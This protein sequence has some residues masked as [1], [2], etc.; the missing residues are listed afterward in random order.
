MKKMIKSVAVFVTTC[1]L[2][3]ASALAAT[4]SVAST[5]ALA[6]A[7]VVVTNWIQ[8][9][10]TGWYNE[11]DKEFTLT[12]AEE[13][14]GLAKLVN[15]GNTFAGKT[16]TLDG[17][18]DLAA[19]TWP[20]IGI[21]NE[22]AVGNAAFQG[23][24]N[25]N[26]HKIAGVTFGESDSGLK[27]RGFFNQI[28]KATIQNVTIECKGF[29]EGTTGT[30]GGAVLVGHA[31]SST[32]ESCVTEGALNVT[33]NA[34]GLVVRISSDQGFGCVIR[35]CTNKANLESNYTKM[36]GIAAFTQT[37]Y[38]TPV[39]ENCVNEGA[40]TSTTAKFDGNYAGMTS[41]RVDGGIGG[42]I[43]WVGYGGSDPFITIKDCSN[44]GS[45]TATSAEKTP[46]G[47]IAGQIWTN[48]TIDGTNTGCVDTLAVDHSPV[49]GL[50]Y[51]TVTEVEGRKVATYIKNEN[52]VPGETTYLVTASNDYGNWIKPVVAL[53][54]NESITFDISLARID[55]T[56]ITAATGVSV[57][58]NG[59]T[60]TYKANPMTYP[61]FLEA[62]ESANYNYDGAGTVVKIAP[63][64]LNFFAHGSGV[65]QTSI[66]H[67]GDI[68]IKNVN[69]TA[70]YPEGDTSK[71]TELIFTNIGA[72]TLEKC[73]FANKV[74][75]STQG[76]STKLVVRN[77]AFTGNTGRYALHCIHSPI[78]EVTGC[79]FDNVRGG[80]YLDKSKT[81]VTV[82]G[83]T[84]ANIIED[85][86]A[87]QF[88]SSTDNPTTITLTGNT[89]DNSGAFIRQ[90]NE[91]LLD[92]LD[93]QEIA[94]NNTLEGGVFTSDTKFFYVAQVNDMKFL[95]LA[96]AI[97][98]VEADDDEVKLLADV[99]YT[100]A[101]ANHV[102]IEKSL[103]L[104]LG[105]YTLTSTTAG[106]AVLRIC[107]PNAENAISVTVKATSG[108][109]K[110]TADRLPIYAGLV[111]RA[112][113]NTIIEGGNYESGWF[114]AVYQNNGLCTIN[115][116]SYK[117]A[118]NTRLLDNYDG[119]GGEFM[120]NGGKF[121]G[122]NP[123][124]MSINQGDHH[125]HTSIKDGMT[126]VLD[127]DGWYTVAEGKL[128]ARVYCT[129]Y[130]TNGGKVGAAHSHCYSTLLDAVNAAQ[131]CDTTITLESNYT[132]RDDEIDALYHLP[133]NSTLDLKGNTLTIEEIE[134]VAKFAGKN[135]TIKNGT[136]THRKEA[137]RQYTL[138]LGDTTLETSVTLEN[139]NIGKAGIHVY[140]GATVTIKNTAVTLYALSKW[141]AVY[142]E[143]GSKVTVESGTFTGSTKDGKDVLYAVN[144]GDIIVT[145][146]TFSKNLDNAHLPD[147]YI[148][149]KAK[150]EDGSF[151]S[152]FIVKKGT[153]AAKIDSVGYE[154]LQD[155]VADS[156]AGDVI[157]LLAD[158]EFETTGTEDGSPMAAKSVTIDGQNQYTFTAIGAGVGPILVT[159]GTL[160]LQNLT[161]V[162]KSVSYKEGAWEFGYLE[163]GGKLVAEGVVFKDPI[164]FE[165]SEA[166][167]KTCTFTG[168]TT[169]LPQYG[170]WIHN[171]EASFEGCTFTGTRGLKAHGQYGSEVATLVVDG[172]QFSVTDK[173]GV[174]L[175]DVPGATVTIKESTFNGVSAGD[176]NQYSFE[177]D[178]DL[179]EFNLTRENNT[180]VFTE[181]GAPAAGTVKAGTYEYDPTA[182]LNAD[183]TA[184]KND[185]GTWTVVEKV[186][187]AQIGE[188]KYETLAE[189]IAA[190]EDGAIITL[191][192]G[193][194]TMPSSVANK[195]ITITGTKDAEIEMLTAVNAT[196]STIS[197]NGVTVKF[198]NDNYE[199]LQH[200][201]KVTYTNCTHIGT[202][203]L[204]AP[205]VEFT[206]CTFEMYDEK[207]EY[208]V[209]TYGA[210]NVTFK[211][212]VFNT[213]GKAI[214]VYTEGAHEA[215]I[216]LS[217]CKFTSNGTYK[218]KAAVELGQSAN[219][220]EA[221]YDLTFTDCTADANFSAN[222]STSN[223]WGNKNS[224]TTASGGGSSV[225]IDGDEVMPKP[226][227]WIQV[228]DTSWYNDT[229]G[230]FTLTTGEELAGVAKLVNAGKTF[231]DKTVKLGAD[232]D[233][234][235]YAWTPIGTSEHPF[236]GAFDGDNKSIRN[237]TAES[238]YYVGLFGLLDT[239]TVK[240][241]LLDGVRISC[242]GCSG[243]LAG[244]VRGENTFDNVDVRNLD[245]T[246]SA[247]YVGGLVG[248]IYNTQM[249]VNTIANC[250]LMVGEGAVNSIR[251]PS[252]YIGGLVGSCTSTTLSIN[253]CTAT[254]LSVLNTAGYVGGFIGYPKTSALSIVDCALDGLIVTAPGEYGFAGGV[255]G[256]V[257]QATA[258][259]ENITVTDITIDAAG[260]DAAGIMARNYGNK[261]VTFKNC[262][263]GGNIQ[264][265]SAGYTSGI[266]SRIEYYGNAIENCSVIG[267]EG[268]NSTIDGGE[269]GGYVGGIYSWMPEGKF[270]VKN[271]RVEN[272]TI[273]AGQKVGGI[274]G[275]LHYGNTASDLTVKNVA[276]LAQGTSPSFGL[277]FGENNAASDKEYKIN[278]IYG[279][280]IDN[281]TVNGASAP[282]ISSVAYGP[283]DSTGGT[284]A[285]ANPVFDDA[286]KIVGGTFD[287]FDENLAENVLASGY[288][289]VKDGE[290]YTVV[291]AAAKIGE[292]YY[293][294][295][296][297][298]IDAAEDGAV[299]T[300]F[301]GTH[302]MPGSVA[303]KNITIKGNANANREDVV[304]EMLTT[305]NATGST[306][307]FEHL[308]AKFDNDIYEGLTHS[309]KITY[310]DCIHIGTEFLYAPTV[311]FTGCT[312]EMYDGKT[313]Y[314]VWTYGAENVTF[315]NCV[316]NTN[317]KAILVYTE[318]AHEAD[319]ALSNCEFKS[320]GTYT[321]KAAVE[322]GQSANGAE[323]S[324]DLSFTDCTADENFSA[325]N[326]TSN[327]W[328]NKNDMT[329]ASGGGS[330]VIITTNGET[331]E[332][333]MPKPAVA[334]VTDADG[335]VIGKYESFDA[336]YE[337]AFERSGEVEIKLLADGVHTST[338]LSYNPGAP[339]TYLTI[340]L[341]GHNIEARSMFYLAWENSS[342]ITVVDETN[343]GSI[344]FEEKACFYIAT[345]NT[346]TIEG[347]QLINNGSIA[348][349]QA[350]NGSFV[351]F[352]GGTYTGNVLAVGSTS[353]ATVTKAEGVDV[354]APEGYEWNDAGKL[355]VG[356]QE[357]VCATIEGQSKMTLSAALAYA[358]A[359][360]GTLIT[361]D[362]GATID[363]SRWT[364]VNMSGVSF[365]LEGN[366]ATITGLKQSLFECIGWGGVTVA[367]RNL[368]MSEPAIVAGSSDGV[369][370]LAGKIA[371][372]AT[373]SIVNCHVSGGSVTTSTYAAGLVGYSGGY[374]AITFDGCSVRNVAISGGS[375]CGALL[376]H[377]NGG[378][379][380]K[381]TMV[382]NNTINNTDKK[383]KSGILIGTLN[384][385]D[386]NSID[387][388]EESESVTQYNGEAVDA[389]L[390]GCLYV[391]VTYN[392]G[393]YF[394]DPTTSYAFNDN[395]NGSVTIEDMIVEKNG[396]YFVVPA[397]AEVG[398]VTYGSIQ[399]AINAATADQ[400]VTLLKDVEEKGAEV[401]VGSGEFFI[402]ILGKAVVVDLGGFTLK[403]SFYLNN[404]AALT[405][406][407]GAIESLEG[408]ASSC[409]ESVGG[410]IVLGEKLSAHSSVRHAI[411][412]KGGTAEINGG[413]Y[414][415]DG[416]STYHVVN[417]S[418]ASTVTINGGTFTS[419]KGNSTSGGNAVMIQ[420]AASTVAIK[421][422]TFTNAAGVEGC[423]SAAAGLVISGG[424]FDT[425]TYDKYLAEGCW[426]FQKYGN[427]YKGLFFVSQK[428]KAPVA[429]VEEQGALTVIAKNYT[430]SMT[431]ETLTL[432]NVY[433]FVAP[434]K[435]GE[436]A[437]DSQY[438][439]WNAD[440]VVS[441]DK[442]IPANSIVLAGNYGSY[443]WISFTNLDAIEAGKEIRLLDLF[444]Y[445]MNY[446]E[447]C[448]LVKEFKCGVTD[449]NGVLDGVNFTVK[450]NMYQTK[451]Y[452][453][454]NTTW[455]DEVEGAEPIT[456]NEV[457]FELGSMRQYVASV[458]DSE[459]TLKGTYESFTTALDNA[460]AGDTVTVLS[461]TVDWGENFTLADDVTIR[462]GTDSDGNEIVVDAPSGYA[463]VGGVLMEPTNWLHVADTRWYNA[464]ATAFT[465]ST[466]EELAGVAKLVNG[467]TTFK[468]VTIT[469]DRDM[470]LAKYV[471]PGIGVYAKNE[472]GNAAFQGIFDGANKTVK[473]MTFADNIGASYAAGD[474]NNYRGL[475]N[476]I[477][478][479]AVV[480]NLIVSGNGF[481]KNPPSG[482]YGG[483][484]IVG[485][486]YRA[487]IRNCVAEGSISGSHNTAGV[488][489][490]IDGSQVL[491]CTN[492][493]AVSGSYNK[494]GGIIAIDQAT[495]NSSAESVVDGCVNN[496]VITSSYAEATPEAGGIGG[497]I[498]WAQYYD[499]ITVKNCTNN[500]EI[501]GGVTKGQIFG[502]SMAVTSIGG[503]NKGLATTMAVNNTAINGLN[504]ATVADGV[505]T[506]VK[507][508]EAGNTYLVTAPN[509]KPVITLA[510]GQSITF[511]QTLA[512]IGD[513]TGIK[514]ATELKSETEGNLVT[515][516][517]KG[518]VV[519]I[520]W[521][522]ETT[523]DE[524]AD[525]ATF[526]LTAKEL[527]GMTFI[528]WSGAYA[529]TAAE[530]QITVTGDIAITANY[531]PDAL[532]T[533]VKDTIEENYKND[534]ELVNVKDIVDLSLQNPTI[535]VGDV[536]GQRVADVGI[537]LMKATTLKDETTGKPNWEPVKEGEPISANWAEDGETILIRLP[538][539]KK[540]QFFRFIPV[541]GLTPPESSEPPATGG[542]VTTQEALKE[543]LSDTTTTKVEVSSG[544]YSDT[545]TV[546]A[547]KEV[548]VKDGSF[549]PPQ[550][551]V[552]IDSQ[553]QTDLVL[554]GGTYTVSEYLQII[555]SQT[556]GS[557][558]TV[559]GGTYKG[560]WLVWGGRDVEVLITGGTFDL[561]GLV[562]SDD[563]TN[564]RTTVT[565]GN[566]TLGD[567]G[568]DSN[569]HNE[570]IITGGTFNKN[571]SKYVPDTH[572]ATESNGLWTVTAR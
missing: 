147:G 160:T 62:L 400:T 35:G 113:T 274:G 311:E 30:F 404:G 63:A 541:N 68:T 106:E 532:Y 308:T 57:E 129:D 482:E 150:N 368:T 344:T 134:T 8:V 230:E 539:D 327:L 82:T 22:S 367:I 378:V 465:L 560:E 342:S 148:D 569:Q 421:G 357:P 295:L 318:G 199:G 324:Y 355:V 43:G 208:A 153:Y 70:T 313:E 563:S 165:G 143:S 323:A 310:T 235:A 505:A 194:H 249:E 75:V 439:T 382:D 228:A 450:L 31:W 337:A 346:L 159:D 1:V 200:A 521:P 21:Y 446:Y 289:A 340:D 557:K 341:N 39:I 238:T 49:D 144:P 292:T 427:D 524:V 137:N 397:V 114:S 375:S 268:T 36:G 149:V 328:G 258:N 121:F 110:T 127:A 430:N 54:I 476:Q 411:R 27:Y 393:E 50:N 275:M 314:A 202:E 257:D 250:D 398:G 488:V 88:G 142:A 550:Y 15:E 299:I 256:Y 243:A 278:T 565:G 169:E 384:V 522:D 477:A 177:S 94:K 109:I 103:T 277:L 214:L 537:R 55:A 300:L 385:S 276:I 570:V 67:T 447:L 443:G 365:T 2:G 146:G 297:E 301:A 474:P 233:L 116:G 396:K 192:D 5:E 175:G 453:D 506:Y 571:P 555:S 220:N 281:A 71:G 383:E 17:N 416:N 333:L 265:K 540:A 503:V 511:D 125:N 309:T 213:N 479:G 489:V 231:A 247:Y 237:L 221:S 548:V 517:A 457:T 412:V 105:V 347:G 128:V 102:L 496:G 239:S 491:A 353:T 336:A 87:V 186:Y 508:L 410:T 306:I 37:N 118:D 158:V 380:V 61:Q 206:G 568:F 444:G 171:G 428:K 99:E 438:S 554:D 89:M 319:I 538:A 198:D 248:R 33:H 441:V 484:M 423:I 130:A 317:G 352:N 155:A 283:K 136:I 492:N 65:Y 451:P 530:A 112:K 391:P 445:K 20:G 459:G 372:S 354:P 552:A 303:N 507:T 154:S 502:A 69:F 418:H 288:L 212:C 210:E 413:T 133:D 436:E 362:E 219:G 191:S 515:Y 267:G 528:G 53:G 107:A 205:T 135:I 207:T 461:G 542:G 500:G 255:V 271:C 298:A 562:V 115:G 533:E 242:T 498:G 279:Y 4:V 406:D 320:N 284:F 124:C 132:L 572:T 28:Y 527:A 363:L 369:G 10:N 156:K 259:F 422:G 139:L 535:Q 437:L 217:G 190:A 379:T 417:V 494:L 263:V 473:G 34:A 296:A 348:M 567:Y 187:A 338:S 302:T 495:Q 122:F 224:M 429:T 513:A 361:L 315:K 377:A 269:N 401:E 469:L 227:N 559:N 395:G 544:T 24:F 371:E 564:F 46:V 293:A 304:V 286:G 512:N 44:I 386:G 229:D 409:I 173:P 262:H 287:V 432:E 93:N 414:V 373:I 48:Y 478:N 433:Q 78:V 556:P 415:A 222:N 294:S 364:A 60:V 197:F 514:A 6:A 241:V 290:L 370:A 468:G 90:L 119:S 211:D 405:I 145:G 216:A 59:T 376:G 454:S 73:T 232:I 85:K 420:D 518:Y 543:A 79:T 464:A 25:G 195:N 536:N 204:Y 76:E 520:T 209:W 345:T 475:F 91:G 38:A 359:N 266:A 545:V 12:M 472:A 120:V 193:T 97:K 390:I 77:C 189:A 485:H 510:A 462:L 26:N 282:V 440:F 322:L 519:T 104:D 349:I 51:A 138:R 95:T 7:E 448:T 184:S 431:E 223:L 546:P 252:Y 442:D 234:S 460:D 23:I 424:T 467:G 419:N 84:F 388:K 72:L 123:A 343:E 426:A 358:K 108:G 9:A 516:K 66:T 455:N 218:D 225:K 471:W 81:S 483:A 399:D 526:T 456:S 260:T 403:G 183:Y 86:G 566:F 163:F 201:A 18:I 334:T 480:E 470:D 350:D 151:A 32:L 547:G 29:A 402:Q 501:N 157:T 558:V 561:W 531:L 394:T 549:T 381:A 246:A 244:D 499:S 360:A 253:N 463:W 42:I 331:S 168:K 19:Y 45:I 240:N 178:T 261:K 280:S 387:V 486:A 196:G 161:I 56:G 493:A 329:T 316:F 408:N 80:I 96:D 182:Y 100:G 166:T 179:S 434:H 351:A 98:V 41:G 176:Q 254:S 285:S 407:N 523:T 13:L 236:S 490:R 529:S 170:C 305:V 366:G 74:G 14:A 273:K 291:P 330:S 504:Y 389:K 226:T 339:A 215:D 167:F 101:E 245:I 270:G 40:I 185:D 3:A 111:G 321:G 435:T 251:S 152:S 487:T 172:C 58:D 131:S 162:D 392:G 497:I 534:N 458:T 525:G 181:D 92:K 425:W 52:L 452:T 64:E 16:I 83:N 466:E 180:I 449:I 356:Y 11:N 141:Y 307:A 272:V 325:N 264:I 509:P 374:V 551:T 126:G 117:S 140:P 188:T 553:G 335:N 326:S 312:F 47:Q 164:L 203:F 481:G 174:A 332:N